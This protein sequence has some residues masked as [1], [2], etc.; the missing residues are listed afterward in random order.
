MVNRQERDAVVDKIS[1]AAV[2]L[3]RFQEYQL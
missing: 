3:V 1:V 2:Y